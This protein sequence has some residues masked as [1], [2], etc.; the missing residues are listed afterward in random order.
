MNIHKLDDMVKGWIAG[1]FSPSVVKTKNFEVAIQTHEK[2][3]K[4]PLH[5]HK[6]FIEINA[7]V[8]GSMKVNGRN[9][10]AG[11][12]FVFDVMEV[13]AAEFLED[14][15]LVVIRPGSDPTDK[16]EVTIK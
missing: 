9:L 6:K 7:I 4:A 15:T 3:Y 8:S 5:L 13:S 1:D 10:T 2:G 12:I 11:D 16:H 14:T